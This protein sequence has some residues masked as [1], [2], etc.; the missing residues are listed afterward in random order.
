MPIATGRR[1]RPAHRF[2]TPRSTREQRRQ[3]AGLGPASSAAL[4]VGVALAILACGPSTP[5]AIQ[6]LAIAFPDATVQGTPDVELD[7]PELEWRF[8]DDSPLPGEDDEGNPVP[9]LDVWQAFHDISGLEIRDG[10]LTGTVSG[11]LPILALSIAEDTLPDD[12][13]SSFTLKLGLPAGEELNVDVMRELEKEEILDRLADSELGDFN[14]ELRPGDEVQTYVL[15]EAQATFGIRGSLSQIRHLLIRPTEVPEGTRFTVESLRATG[16]V[17]ELSKLPSGFGWHGLAEIYRETVVSRS[18]ETV[19]FDVEAGDASWLDLVV[20]TPGDH[21][22]TFRAVAETSGGEVVERQRTVTEP[23]RWFEL[24]LDLAG[25]DGPLRVSLELESEEPGRL[26]FWGGPTVR[27]RDARAAVSEPSEHRLALSDRGAP[28]G[29]VLFLADTLR[30]DHLDAWGYERETAPELTRLASEGTLFE[31]NLSQGTW[32]KIAVPAVLTSLYA[33]THGITDVPHRLPASVTTLAEAF[34]DAGYATFHTSSVPF[35]GKNSNLQQGVE[36]LH[37]RGSLDLGDYGSKTARPYVDEFLAW[38]ETHHDAP[39]FAFVHVFDP[40]SPFRPRPPFDR[41]WI[42]AEGAADLADHFESLRESTDFHGLPDR[43]HLEDAKIDEEEYVRG[44][45]AWYDGSIRAM[46]AEIGKMMEGLEALGIVDDV[47]IGF[48][49]D[50]G[51]EFLE[52]GRSW[53]GQ[54]VYGEMVDVP[55]FIRWPGVVP[56]H[57]VA[58]STQSIDLM[59]TLLELARVPVPEQAQGRSLLPLLVAAAAGES[60][61]EHGWNDPPVF[62]ERADSES[63]SVDGLP[64]AYAVIHDGWKLIWNVVVRDERPELELFDHRADPLDLEN[65]ADQHPERVAELKKLIEGWRTRAEEAKVSDEGL[66]DEMDPE[67]LE[68]L[69]ALGYVN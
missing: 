32:T 14:L 11:P 52:H 64:D 22:V 27:H 43:K 25:H 61:Q 17:E 45:L 48:V 40:H 53:H 12:R 55:M 30:R 20:G 26:G 13:P 46:D 1:T 39:F 58:S 35:S 5:P 18:P 60:P 34:R 69:R 63:E 33:T 28:R 38:L 36:V 10:V 21:P 2:S 50:H 59:P 47:L 62:T 29:V 15:G 42:D 41:R 66:E 54:S 67:E 6:S 4:L 68:R 57:R 49:A 19:T 7:F 44:A 9:P 3:A 56:S 8:G 24:D 23:Y 51:E 16:R 31:D 37:E 65:L